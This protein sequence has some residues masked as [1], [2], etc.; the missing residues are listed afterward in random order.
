MR[1]L[2]AY[3]GKL[4][5]C[6][7]TS[8]ILPATFLTVPRNPFLVFSIAKKSDI[9][10][11]MRD[12]FPTRAAKFSLYHVSTL[13]TA[14]LSSCPTFSISAASG[15]INVSSSPSALCAVSWTSSIILAE[16][17]AA[18]EQA[19]VTFEAV[20]LAKSTTWSARFC[21][22]WSLELSS[23][24]EFDTNPFVTWV[25]LRSIS[26]IRESTSMVKFCISF[27]DFWVTLSTSCRTWMPSC[28]TF[29]P[30]SLNSCEEFRASL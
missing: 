10:C 23:W 13:V 24:R 22:S 9:I 3:S 17:L 12:I 4:F 16:K 28:S 5:R 15:P 18:F 7:K 26:S 30:N 29:S 6:C 1:A 19:P 14:V 8:F 11:A 2:L 25:K 27:N 21:I 20:P